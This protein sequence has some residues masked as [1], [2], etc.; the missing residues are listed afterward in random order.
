MRLPTTFGPA[1]A[2]TPFA[3][4]EGPSFGAAQVGR[5]FAAALA[6]LALTTAPMHGDFV[7]APLRGVAAAKELA[8][9][10]GSRVNKDP[11]S[12][13]RL[14]LPA[15]P[16]DLKEVQLKLEEAQDSL[17]RLLLSNAGAAVGTA[18][19]TLSGKT[20]QIIKAV[21]A[22]TAPQAQE[23]LAGVKDSIDQLQASISSGNA[24]AALKDV[25]G[26]LAKVEAVEQLIADGFTQPVPP[27]EFD[28]LPWLKGRATLAFELKRPGGK[29]DVDGKLYDKLQLTT[30]VDGYTAPITAGNFVDLVNK[31]FYTDMTIQR[32][33]GFVVQTGDPTAEG[34]GAVKNGYVP[35]G[36]SEVRKIP[37]EVYA[38][39]D[40]KPLYGSTF[41]DDGRGGY[42]AALPFN[43]Y[44]ALGMAREEYDPDSASSQWFWLLFDSD[45]TPAGKNLLDGRYACFGYTVDGA[46]LLSDVK[47]GDVIVSGKVVSGLSNLQNAN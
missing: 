40:K 7:P 45:L 47:E 27:S 46:R 35:P 21:P 4:T 42:A 33:D 39:G 5:A 31:G 28:G 18:K 38:Q 6:A 37:L 20:G 22:N 30:I 3:R 44:G 12:L 14:A 17:T 1:H 34:K 24:G 41:D 10:S 13:L 16:K 32:S 19:G 25:E 2:P 8:S 23:L 26:A 36:K 11:K 29:F 9:G 43:A 15:Q